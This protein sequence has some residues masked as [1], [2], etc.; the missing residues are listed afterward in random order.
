M[1]RR[2][3]RRVVAALPAELLPRLPREPCEA[4][5][6][7]PQRVGHP[8]DGRERLGIHP[9]KLR[10][11]VVAD[12]VAGVAV[13]QVGAVGDVAETVGRAVVLRLPPGAA[14][15]RP[16]D[17]P[18]APAGC[19]RARRFRCRARDSKAPSRRRPRGCAP[20]RSCS[21]IFPR[22][23][24]R[25]RSAPPS[26]RPRS[27]RP[28]PR[29]RLDLDPAQVERDSILFAH[30]AHELFVPVALLPA[31]AV[32]EVAGAHRQAKVGERAQKIKQGDRVGA[33]RNRRRD[34]VTLP[35]HGKLFN[36]R[37]RLTVHRAPAPNS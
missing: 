23:R 19:R 5:G 25:R 34:R 28:L 18:R 17:R 3:P 15:E 16:H 9:E 27:T 24:R 11:D 2:E 8:P 29:E 37:P 7:P 10:Q 6:V 12:V 30:R 31:Q 4:V 21:G 1:Q 26:P 13:G 35:E 36:C 22:A 33:A 14:D 20:S 32:V